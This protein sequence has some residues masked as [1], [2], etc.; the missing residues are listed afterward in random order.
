MIN[1][2]STKLA[3]GNLIAVSLL[4]L[5]ANAAAQS[6]AP[7]DNIRTELVRGEA[8]ASASPALKDGTLAPKMLASKEIEA[9]LSGNT[10]RRN[11][12]LAI[13]FA[14]GGAGTAWGTDWA[15]DKSAR[16]PASDKPGDAYDR[17]DGSCRRKTIYTVSH[18]W[19]T[20]KDKLCQKWAEGGTE[21]SEC[22]L[23]GV[24]YDRVL[25]FKDGGQGLEGL[26][27]DLR[28]GKALAQ[29]SD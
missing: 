3:L 1:A 11:D 13:Y 25:L 4:G 23:V 27:M 7:V 20:D 17:R 29:A 6:N 16:C 19:W 18:S 12:R 24:L 14:P 2:S 28:A 5:S 15:A 21:K 10:L 22:W 8:H 9:L 26:P